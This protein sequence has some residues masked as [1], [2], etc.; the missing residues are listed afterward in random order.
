[1][2]RKSNAMKSI[3]KEFEENEDLKRVVEKGAQVVFNHLYPKKPV[4]P[5]SFTCI[6]KTVDAFTTSDGIDIKIDYTSN[7]NNDGKE[8]IWLRQGME[9]MIILKADIP[10][11]IEAL[12]KV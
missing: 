12:K 4:K 3:E 9:T 5:P 2:G 10:R 1:M 8:Y 6:E 11:L 7:F